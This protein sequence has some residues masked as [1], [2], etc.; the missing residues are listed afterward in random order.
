[1][2]NIICCFIILFLFFA[3]N[4]KAEF[5][6]KLS[7]DKDKFLEGESIFC[8]VSFVN[9]SQNSDSLIYEAINEDFNQMEL[10]KSDGSK[11][12]IN[13]FIS[14]FVGRVPYVKFSPHQ[15]HEDILNLL[16]YRGNV[17]LKHAT[18]GMRMYL[19]KGDYTLNY[20]YNT[21]VSNEI[22]FT[23]SEPQDM[24]RY[25]LNRLIEAYEIPDINFRTADSIILKKD[26]Y[27]DIVLNHPE[28]IYWE[29]AVYRYNEESN[30]L[31]LDYTDIHINKEFVKRFPNSY[32]I[33]HVLINLC[34]AMYLYEG[35]LA[36]VEAYLGQLIENFENYAVSGAAKE[37]LLKKEYLN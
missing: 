21:L 24:E 9:N 25:V 37:Q 22:S 20:K 10:K 17:I 5:K 16:K 36:A 2:K 26:I 1:M 35:G 7:L 12:V 6:V 27:Y 23:V 18:L 28:S 13:G 33:R 15:V 19:S 31:K 14:D 8:H 30:W 29:E 32:F 4:G 34:Q 11:I 3:N